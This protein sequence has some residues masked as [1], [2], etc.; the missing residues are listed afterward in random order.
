[1]HGTG[2]A[3]G[4]IGAGAAMAMSAQRY[5]AAMSSICGDARRDARRPL[6]RARVERPGAARCH[7]DGGAPRSAPARP[8]A[9]LSTPSPG[10][11]AD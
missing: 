1:M 2:V 10:A 3:I 7:L 8:G 5:A 6:G 4:Q 9:A 11:A